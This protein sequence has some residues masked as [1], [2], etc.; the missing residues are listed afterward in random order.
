MLILL[1]NIGSNVWLLFA[2]VFMVHF[3]NN[4]AITLTVG[5]LCS[6]TV[7]PMLMATAS[8]VVIAVGE[9][10]GGGLSPIIAGNLPSALVSR[11]C[12][13]Y[14]SARLLLGFC[15]ACCSKKPGLFR[16][17]AQYEK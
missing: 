11:I 16:K 9:L 10:L 13:G 17:E 5:P 6:E 4:A 14:P 7:P 15:F 3:F 8:G 12:C 2:A 1:A